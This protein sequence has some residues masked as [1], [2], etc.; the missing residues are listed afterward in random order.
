ATSPVQPTAGMSLRLRDFGVATP[1]GEPVLTGLD[2]D[3]A[4]G[5]H[6]AIMGESGAGK[7]TLLEALARLRPAVGSIELGGAP[8]AAIEEQRLRADIGFLGQRPRLVTGSIADNI[9][10][11]RPDACMTAVMAAARQALVGAFADALPQGLDTLIGENG[12][13]LSGGEAQRV[14][15]ARL[16][17]RAPGL[18]LLDEPTAHLDTETEAAMLDHLL[19][20]A[21]RRTL[22]VVTHSLRVAERMDRAYVLVGE[23]LLPALRPGRHRSDAARDAA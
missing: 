13:G 20:F 14:A 17:L 9:R 7:S 15:L 16:Y 1:A 4:A 5:E 8:L 6:V 2:L 18:I 21:R 23:Q 12:L 19:A 22:I 3:I 11:G 10:L